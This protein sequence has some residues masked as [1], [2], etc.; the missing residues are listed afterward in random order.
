M[1][2]GLELGIDCG[3]ACSL[4]CT[5][6]AK[7]P[8][9]LWARSFEIA[10]STYTAAAYIQNPNSGAGARAARYSFQLFDD[11]N[12]LVVE[13][14]G[15]VDLPPVRTIPVIEAGIDVGHRT[16]ARTLF[17]FSALP[18]WDTVTAP[19][20]VLHLTQQNLSRTPQGFRQT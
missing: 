7:A 11:Q 13:K 19:I 14:D 18:A 5:D 9:V 2:N 8:T 15:V 16:V 17:S 12:I 3:G 1:Q 6:Q 4:I 20:P 10:S